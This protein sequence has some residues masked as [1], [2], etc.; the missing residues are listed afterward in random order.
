MEYSPTALLRQLGLSKNATLV[1]LALLKSGPETIARIAINAGIER[2]L[3][4][5]ALPELVK[6]GLMAK[7]PRGKRSYY[8]ARSPGKLRELL[9]ALTTSLEHTLPTLEERFALSG[10]RPHVTYLEGRTGI[11]S[12]YEDIIETLPRGGVFYR[13][14]SGLGARKHEHYVPK[15]YRAKR[16]AKKLERYVITNKQTAA[17]KSSRLERAVKSIPEG[18]DLFAYNVTE[19]IYGTKTAFVDYNTESAIIIENPI[20]AKFQERLFK[21]LYQRL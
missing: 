2:P 19:L 11:V 16:D 14:S 15:D 10:D 17:R 4:Y 3:V 18:S 20:I 7:A 8:S 21:L 5:K 12:V 6:G 13:Y 1:Y 9:S